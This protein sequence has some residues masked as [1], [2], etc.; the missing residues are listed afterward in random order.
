M[1][2]DYET[3]RGNLEK[4]VVWYATKASER[5]EATTRLQLI[6]EIFFNCLGWDKEDSVLEEPYQGEY[7]DYTF[8]APRR[9]LIVEAKKEGNY[10]EVP[11]GK[12]HLEYS[13]AALMRD[14]PNLKAAIEQAAGYCQLRG[15]PFG[16]IFNGHQIVAFVATRNDGLPPFQGKALVFPSLDFMLSNF[17]EL[18][19]A[20]SKPAIEQKKLYTRLIGDIL[21]ELPPKLSSSIIG[22][23]GVVNRNVFQTN[24][25]IISDFVIEDLALSHDLQPHFLE[26]CYSQSGALSQYALVSK[27]ILQARYAALFS[28]DT[29]GPTLV[30]AVNKEWISPELLADSLS[31]RPI[32]LIRGVGAGK[33]TF[34]RHLIK[35]DAANV[36]ENAI[37][38]YIDFGSQATLSMDLRIFTHGSLILKASLSEWRASLAYKSAGKPSKARIRSCKVESG[39]T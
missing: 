30:P 28:Q 9:V 27:S 18:W 35:V 12:D 31:R 8:I 14:Y 34:I 7:A 39:V 2:S 37:S 11:A 10:F 29:P 3:C 16:V 19:Q 17:H 33:T 21:P 32:L 22:Y 1:A 4:L 6:D 36:F 25:H 5:N 24:L 15:V 13:L 23:P 26:E 20:L 38:L